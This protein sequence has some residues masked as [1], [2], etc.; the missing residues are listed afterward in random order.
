VRIH[1]QTERAVLV[2]ALLMV[3]TS[4]APR[5]VLAAPAGAAPIVWPL[6]ITAGGGTIRLYEP[7]VRAW[8]NYTQMKGVA[9]IAVTLPG[10]ASPVYGTLSFS[11]LASAD[12][13]S[14][15]VAL[16]NPKIDSTSWPTASQA[17]AALL[18]AFLKTNL[19]LAGKPFLPLAMVL[20][21]LPPSAR[22]HTIPLRSN[23]PV[24]YVRQ[25]P[26]VLVVFD[27]K[28]SFAPIAGTHLTYAVNTNWEIIHDPSQGLYYV[29]AR[30]GWYSSPGS[31]GPFTPTVAPAS[32]AAIP[33]TGPL[34]YVHAALKAPK[35]TGAVPHVIVSTVPSALIDIAGQPQFT[36]IAGTQLRYVKNTKSDVFFSLDTTIWYVLLSGRWFSAANL[37]GP[38]TF[39]SGNLPADFK[40]IPEDSP[41]GRVLVSVPGTTQAFYAA[42]V[43]QVPHVTS[44]DPASATLKVTY[45]SGAPV[46][47]PIPTTSLQY[48]VNTSSD[49]IKVDAAQY[50]ACA[51]GVW[52]RA[53][54]PL[55]PWT[56]ASYVPSVIYSI[57]E[58]SPLYH[59]TFVHVY[60]AQGAVATA[61]T[62]PPTPRPDQTYHD[63]PASELS[64]GDRAA[65]Y[66][67]AT[68]GYVNGYAA[69]WGG[70]AQGTGY[71]TPGY[72]TLWVSN[73]PTYGNFSDTTYARQQAEANMPRSVTMQAPAVP[74]H[75]PRSVPG[76]DTNVY[77]A[78]DGVYRVV[79]GTWQKNSAGDTWALSALPPASLQHDE[80]ARLAGYAGTVS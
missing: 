74:G 59:V 8:P 55:G 16:V 80:R 40:K 64:Q 67:A 52:F 56:A 19:R 72:G 46:F 70:Y 75:G 6:S 14:G 39:A 61:P 53:S 31:S 26:A 57:P 68:A 5:T 30:S 17:D 18:D 41:R 3:F 62:P 24:I 35:P 42:S 77:A 22:P 58:S 36:S 37:N 65:Y 79:S 71:Y 45:R 50:F 63:T 47:E 34:S 1:L 43:S 2:A 27:G 32:F 13:P 73:P 54:S 25:S 33:A 38:W 9:A 51:Q 4:A 12:V 20:S 7:Q 23:P 78:D 21:S 48:A 10:A 11:S 28:P 76:P 69:G 15:M 49:V 66:Y 29:H 60:N 44:V